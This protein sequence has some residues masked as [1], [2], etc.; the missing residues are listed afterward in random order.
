MADDNSF[1]NQPKKDWKSAMDDEN[2]LGNKKAR[3]KSGRLGVLG[4]SMMLMGAVIIGGIAALLYLIWSF[5]IESGAKAAEDAGLVPVTSE[6]APGRPKSADVL[7]RIA[8]SKREGEKLFPELANAWMRARGYTSVSTSTERDTITISGNKD[9]KSKR[10]LIAKSSAKGG[11]E[12]MIQGRVEGVFSSRPI[13]SGEADRLSA[14]GDMFGP[15]NEKVIGHDISFVYV[16]SSNPITNMNGETLGRILSGEITDWSEIS[17]KKEGEITI[18]VENLGVD[19]NLGILAKILGER[20]MVETSKSLETPDDVLGA[21]ARDSNAIGFSHKPSS[22][23]GVK[24]IALNER[25]AGTFDPN[26]FNISTEAYPFTERLYLYI[27]SNNSAPELADFA[28]FALSPAGQEIV[29]KLG[30]GAQ[31]VAAE[32]VKAPVDAPN[33]YADFAKSSQRMNFDIRFLQGANELDNKAKA[34]LIRFQAFVQKQSIDP[35]RIAIFGFADNVGAQA[36][37]L[38]LGQSRAEAVSKKLS[39]IGLAPALIRSYGDAMA[40]GAN[41]YEAGRIKNRRVEVWICPPP[42]CPLM[43]VVVDN[44]KPVNLP[45]N[46]DIP[47]GVH[48]GRPPSTDGADAPKG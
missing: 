46:N 17:D 22:F 3:R 48:F 36:T 19:K 34:D 29:K 16:N 11:F 6:F 39:E 9:G 42:A 7:F 25:N 45:N 4:W 18:K 33:D 12:G 27:G 10:I 2:E 23:S 32:S 26:D 14:Y 35:K 8:G 1:S 31:Q 37:N 38:G 47:S 30:Y 41:A 15:Q 43:N 28:D 44:S 13:E 21:V 24:N 40:V 5:Q 20:E